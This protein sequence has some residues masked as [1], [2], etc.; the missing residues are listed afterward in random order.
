MNQA[1]KSPLDGLP[2]TITSDIEL[3]TPNM[4]RY[5][6]DTAHFERQRNI[7]KANVDRLAKEMTAGRFN[8]GTQIFICVLPDG[9]RVII[10]GNHTLEAV[11][12]SAVPQILTITLRTVA[13]L[14]EAGRIYAVFDIQKLRSWRDSLRAV[15]VADDIPNAAKVLTAIG[16][17]EC[18]FGH[19]SNVAASRLDRIDRI[20]VYRDAAVLFSELTKNAN[21]KNVLNLKRAGVLAV[22][23]ETL[24]HQPSAAYDFWLS[25]AH[26]DG[27]LIGTPE[28]SLLNWLRAN[29]VAA[30]QNGQKEHA[31]AAAVAWNAKFKSKS[32]GSVRPNAMASFYLL[33]TPYHKG[34][35]GAIEERLI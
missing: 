13:D 24:K 10:N 22:V 3:I 23:L 19:S 1:A 2:Y 30:S 5:L 26:D 28:K 27:L 8:P 15:G 33:G 17:I 35:S 34:I 11:A 25:V 4:A 6:R 31:R 18:G 7:S 16:V 20:E 9:S 12:L 29:T 21:S 14:D 32:I